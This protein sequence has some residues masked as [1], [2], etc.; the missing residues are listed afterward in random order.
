MIRTSA[1]A[2]LKTVPRVPTV[3]QWVKNLTVATPV[4]PVCGFEP[5]T[6]GGMGLWV[7]GS[8]VATAVV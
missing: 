3:V 1:K 5:Q 7:K 4:T 6:C 8:G 2:N